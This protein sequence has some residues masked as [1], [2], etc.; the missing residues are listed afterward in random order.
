MENNDPEGG[1]ILGIRPGIDKEPVRL[2][3]TPRYDGMQEVSPDGHWMVYASDVT[4]RF[5]IYVVPFP[6]TNAG[7]WQISS[8]GGVWPKWSAH[9]NE[10]VYREPRGD[11]FAAAVRTAPTFSFDK[12][13]RLFVAKRSEFLFNGYTVSPDGQR[14]L[15]I[16]L[17]GAGVPDKLIVVEN[18][19]EE[20]RGK[21]RN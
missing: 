6:N 14:F 9:G 12:P 10:V 15:M 16:R 1:D 8:G 2:V 5:E 4:G 7:K 18:W 20:L 13:R 11:V 19:F 17:V 21:G 3:A